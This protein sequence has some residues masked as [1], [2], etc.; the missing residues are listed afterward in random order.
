MAIT[1][2]QK[3]A[4]IGVLSISTTVLSVLFTLKMTHTPPFETLEQEKVRVLK[5]HQPI[6]QSKAAGIQ[7]IQSTSQGVQCLIGCYLYDMS[8]LKHL[9]SASQSVMKVRLE[10]MLHP[11]KIPTK[12]D[13]FA[14]PEEDRIV[15]IKYSGDSCPVDHLCDGI[16]DWFINKFNKVWDETIVRNKGS[17]SGSWPAPNVMRDMRRDLDDVVQRGGKGVIHIAFPDF[18]DGEDVLSEL[19]RLKVDINGGQLETMW[20]TV[21]DDR[22]RREIRLTVKVLE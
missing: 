9:D 14:I 18:C 7:C 17:L 20:E 8:A 13:D 2:K 10:S 21:T 1:H 15:E 3:N 11:C 12:F 6:P 16:K 19:H 4:V 5:A 22:I